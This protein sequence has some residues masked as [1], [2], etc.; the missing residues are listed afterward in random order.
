MITYVENIKNVKEYN[1]LSEAVGWGKRREE[2]IKN[3][4]EKTLFSISAYDSGEIVGYG[5]VVGDET[6]FLYIQDV[7]VDPDYQNQKIGTNIM[8]KLMEKAEEYKR[9][10]PEVRIYV[11]PD[12]GKENFYRKFGFITRKEAH[13][14]DGMIWKPQPKESKLWNWEDEIDP[15]ELEEVMDIL[16]HDGVIIFPTDTV[17][18]LACNCFSTKAIEKI[19]EIKQRAKYKPISVL[20]DSVEKINMVATISEKEQALVEK[21]MPGALTIVMDKKEHVP[22]ILTA[23]LPTVGVRIPNN[24]IALTILKNYPYPLATTSANESGEEAGVDV[25]DFITYFDGKVDAII[26]GGTTD[27]QVAST[28]IRV[29]NDQITTIREGSIKIEE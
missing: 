18:G 29:E 10:Y 3:A 4:Q 6:M 5:R 16:D 9:I 12:Y 14:G 23:S 21:Y 20:T 17:Y 25:Q 8:E 13:L 2:E 7:M 19:F 28:I 27:I 26:D 15:K 22:D 1:K 11:G 24:H